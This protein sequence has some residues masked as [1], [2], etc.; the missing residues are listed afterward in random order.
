MDVRNCPRCGSIFLYCGLRLCENC[1][2]IEEEEFEKVKA[3]LQKNPGT[4]VEKVAEDTG[5]SL[6]QIMS[7]IRNGRLSEETKNFSGDVLFCERCQK[8]ISEG[9]MCLECQRELT[10]TFLKTQTKIREQKAQKETD[11]TKEAKVRFLNKARDNK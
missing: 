8:P 2:K 1:R 3:Y 6:Q 7:F 11:K 4:T 9:K 10:Q 5:V